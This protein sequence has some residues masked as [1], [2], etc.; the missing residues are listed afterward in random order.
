MIVRVL[1]RTNLRDAQLSRLAHRCDLTVYHDNVP[2]GNADRIVAR[3]KG[4]DIVIVNAF[5][6]VTA[7]AIAQL[8]ALRLIVSCSAGIDHIDRVACDN[9]GIRVEWFPGYCARTLAE[10]TLAY[11]LMG[12]NRIPDAIDDVRA[13][14]WD[15]M[16]FEGREAR[17]R[18][19]AVIGTGATGKIV[20]Q[21]CRALGFDVQGANSKTSRAQVALMLE[22]ADVVTLHLSRHPDAPPFLRAGPLGLLK[23]DVVIVNTARGG[24]VDDDALAQFLRERPRATAFLDV[25]ATEPMSPHSPYRGLPNAVVTP[26]IGWNSAEADTRLANL[27]MTAVTDYLNRSE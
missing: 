27:T 15:Y 23:D 14:N 21:L 1:G 2:A 16:G 6:P 4:A 20:V 3:A 12:L 19:V 25:L 26:H 17:D 9:A 13:G 10:K 11:I 24:L 18:R 7:E 22:H 5:T 8:P